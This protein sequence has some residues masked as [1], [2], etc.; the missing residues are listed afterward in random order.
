MVH[1]SAASLCRYVA[2]AGGEGTT[3]NRFYSLNLRWALGPCPDKHMERLPLSLI[4]FKSGRFS[5]S[6]TMLPLKSPDLRESIALVLIS[7]TGQ[8][9]PHGWR[10]EERAVLPGGE[11]QAAV[12]AS[13]LRSPRCR[14][15]SKAKQGWEEWVGVG[16]L[17]P[18]LPST[19]EGIGTTPFGLNY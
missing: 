18:R 14:E 19:H 15:T 2:G 16:I 6:V 3:P 10:C 12:K 17:F 13:L 11:A 1:G 7:D 5:L 8:K 9:Y 4:R